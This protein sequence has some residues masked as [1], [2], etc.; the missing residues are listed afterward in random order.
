MYPWTSL[1][2]SLEHHTPPAPPPLGRGICIST[3][4][5]SQLLEQAPDSCLLPTTLGRMLA[6]FFVF[7]LSQ[8]GTAS[9]VSLLLLL[10][11]YDLFSTEQLERFI[12]SCDFSAQNLPM[13]P[14]SLGVKATALTM[15]S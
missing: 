9:L 3:P 6:V 15:T 13:A 8:P 2:P 14:I 10:I 11:F 4:T 12:R 1:D 7:F 5:A